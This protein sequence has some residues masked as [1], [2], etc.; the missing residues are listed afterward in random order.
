MTFE[1][2]LNLVKQLSVA[3]KLRLIKSIVPEI[4]RELVVAQTPR[5]S[6]WGL[7]ADLGTAPSAEDIDEVRSEEWANFPREDF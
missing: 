2:V 4:E 1:A 3:E 5:K 7:C 6:L